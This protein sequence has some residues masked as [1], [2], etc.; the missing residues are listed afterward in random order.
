[1]GDYLASRG[2][3][4]GRLNAEL[5][6]A[7]VLGLRR[8]D[9]YL[10]FDRP[11]SAEELAELKSRLKRRL[12]HEPL[13]YIEGSAAFRTLEL[14]VA[15]RVLIPRPETELLVGAV[16]AWAG[17]HPGADVLDLGTGSGAIALSLRAEGR[18][19]RIIG[20]D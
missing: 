16:L 5:L 13:Q 14:S 18:F 10:Q 12:R 20:T 15:P 9:L 6:L 19:G 1:T 7:G 2:L 4:D 3:P 17:D 8:L 11:L